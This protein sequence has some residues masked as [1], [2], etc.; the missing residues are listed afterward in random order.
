[1]AQ[2]APT[3]PATR[4]RS[5]S[6]KDSKKRSNA[7]PSQGAA[8]AKSLA[9]RIR[10]FAPAGSA[11]ELT[12]TVG[13]YERHLSA[14]LVLAE[15]TRKAYLTDLLQYLQFVFT[16]E[17]LTG[18][19]NTV[20]SAYDAHTI[21]A[22]LA[23][24]F[25]TRSRTTVARK[26]AALRAFFAFA[27]RGHTDASPA[28]AVTAPKVPRHLPVHLDTDDV[29]AVLTAAAHEAECSDGARR[30][31]WLRNHAMLEVLYSTGLRA[32]ELVNLSDR[33]LD[34]D[35]GVLRVENGKGGKQR[36]VPIGDEA[37]GAIDR[38]RA[39]FP[40]A[41]KDETAVFLNRYGKRLNVRSVGRILDAAIDHAALATQ[42]SPHA[43]RHS[44]ATHLLENGADLR[45][46]QEMLGHASISTTQKYT[47]LDLKKLSSIY[48]RAHPR[49]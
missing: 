24:E 29:E 5:K 38:Y 28:E 22:F 37:L 1:M 31:Q 44:F 27:T 15:R 49:A 26:L 39:E 12:R 19:K 47:H 40:D 36:I 16:R 14:E 13:D 20:A 8:A 9:D 2:K 21:R 48:D 32:S 34:R 25:E 10:E 23:G 30:L 18:G 46:I 17:N 42:A 41:W 35:L 33:D 7:A 11:E 45:A 43:L 6:P 3:R 4:K